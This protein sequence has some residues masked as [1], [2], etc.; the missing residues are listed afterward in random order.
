MKINEAVESETGKK[1][2]TGNR[3]AESRRK[4]GLG[5]WNGVLWA[6]AEVMVV[7]VLKL[8]WAGNYGGLLW[9]TAT[10]QK[11]RNG[12]VRELGE[13]EGNKGERDDPQST[14]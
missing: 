13:R 5:F 12:R 11:G 6:G 3:V 1:K 14:T 7:V 10:E 8:A 2:K 4:S 9:H